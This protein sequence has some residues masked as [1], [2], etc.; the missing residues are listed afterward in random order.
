MGLKSTTEYDIR[1]KLLNKL[2]S[3]GDKVTLDL[4]STE[5]KRMIN[6]K[7]DT[8]LIE[9]QKSEAVV[10][11]VYTNKKPKSTPKYPCWFCGG[12]HFANECSYKKH[13]CE[14]CKIVGHKEGYCNVFKNNKKKP[15]QYLKQKGFNKKVKSGNF[16]TKTI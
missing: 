4:L 5:C 7:M 10:K 11:Q 2:E 6:L 3:E 1:T 8:V 12:M 16:E 9:N 15:K 14:Q 13:K